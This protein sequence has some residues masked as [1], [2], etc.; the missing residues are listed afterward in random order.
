MIKFY[1]DTLRTLVFKEYETKQQMLLPPSLDE[2]IPDD[3]VVRVVDDTIDHIDVDSLISAYP[4]GGSSAY[5]PVM[6]FK[7][8]VFAYT[9]KIYSSRQIA[10]AL[11]ENILFMWLSGNNTPDFRTINRF[12]SG[13]LKETLKDLFA[14]MTE[15]LITEGYVSFKNYFLDGTK[16][17]A[18]ANKY[19]W[20]WRRATEKFHQR[21]SGQIDDLMDHIDKINEEEDR[22]Y[23][24]HD[25]DEI[26]GSD[27]PLSEK[28]KVLTDKINKKLREEAE[29]EDLKKIQKKIDS[30]YAPRAEK[31]EKQMELF[32][33]RNSYSKTDTDATFMRMKDD[34]MKNGQLKPGYNV[35]IGTEEQFV[36]WYSL[37]SSPNDIPTF[38][39]HMDEL[40]EKIGDYPE[41]VVADSG[42]GN[43]ENYNYCDDQ[44]IEKYIKFTFFHKE[45]KRKFKKNIYRKENWPYDPNTDTLCCP[46]GKTFRFDYVKKSLTKSGYELKEKIYRGPGCNGCSHRKLCCRGSSDRAVQRR[47][48]MEKHKEDVRRLLMSKE[49]LKMRSK[50]PIEPESVFGQIKQNLGFRRFRLRGMKNVSTEWGIVSMAHNMRKLAARKR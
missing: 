41:R 29:R 23:G 1:M 19:T 30:D 34:A 10:K 38:I 28:I 46:E 50:R 24:D 45:Q 17:E 33:G 39:P 9:Q 42:Y 6:M 44:N 12:R 20:V 36:L 37:H 35:Q 32:N 18:N 13:R 26:P 21:L 49:G 8:L 16:I 22:I 25:L 11:R 5:H 43:E 14:S 15:L 48:N 7:V 40:K 2:L 27:K 4:G 31:Y 47:E 3:H